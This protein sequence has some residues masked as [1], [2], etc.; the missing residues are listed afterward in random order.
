[1][2][3][4]HRRIQRELQ[5]RLLDLAF[6]VGGDIL[7][8]ALQGGKETGAVDQS[9]VH[10]NGDQA[11]MSEPASNGDAVGQNV[12]IS[13]PPTINTPS[14]QTFTFRKRT[15]IQFLL[16]TVDTWYGAFFQD[17]TP[18]GE[19]NNPEGGNDWV[20][21]NAWNVVPV[22][23]TGLYMNL[24]ELGF[25][26]RMP[27]YRYKSAKVQFTNF[28]IHSSSLQDG[29][30]RWIQNTSGV[31]VYSQQIDSK[32]FIPWF[33][34]NAYRGATEGQTGFCS[35]LAVEQMMSDTGVYQL[36][37]PTLALA[38]Q[39]PPSATVESEISPE[40]QSN[41]CIIPDLNRQSHVQMD[42][43]VHTST[44]FNVPERQWRSK[45]LSHPQGGKVA[46]G[47]KQLFPIDAPTTDNILTHLTW[48]LPT[49]S[50]TTIRQGM[51][52]QSYLRGLNNPITMNPN[53]PVGAGS[54]NVL[55][56]NRDWQ[57]PTHETISFEQEV[58]MNR[59]PNDY[60]SPGWQHET[61]QG[62]AEPTQRLLGLGK[63]DVPS[64]RAALITSQHN[65]S[66]Q[67]KGD[68]W[69]MK[70]NIPSAFQQEGTT[71]DL[72]MNA[73]I[74][75]EIDVEV[76]FCT[77]DLM[78][79]NKTFV[80]EPTWD[81]P[82]T[83]LAQMPAQSYL[84]DMFNFQATGYRDK[85]M[86]L[87]RGFPSTALNGASPY[88]NLMDSLADGRPIPMGNAGTGTNCVQSDM[89]TRSEFYAV[90]DS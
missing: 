38:A 72:F 87:A 79:Y 60:N 55:N 8:S 73:F 9:G 20:T 7:G 41:T 24:A 51:K 52:D 28:N 18:I 17:R 15:P 78:M 68:L 11:A 85:I 39:R 40:M 49:E 75:T 54:T 4:I 46:V 34:Y 48:N 69:I 21:C 45:L 71:P 64:G 30:I 22:R 12:I 76:D 27:K 36:W 10:S 86:G 81:I 44:I 19:G 84:D 31:A 35:H 57:F 43:P 42:K 67:N 3:D 66:Q 1:M 77:N 13:L 6:T 80:W 32:K 88:V 82:G 33:T 65:Q 16:N 37:K 25:I 59:L 26:Q 61:T 29:A 50:T 70:F 47:T 83:H 74:E 89:A 63:I 62:V 53:R 5:N 23:S 58:S 14:I 90:P 56:G 2:D